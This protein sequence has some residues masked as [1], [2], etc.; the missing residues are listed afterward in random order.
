[1]LNRESIA[2]RIPHQ[3]NMCLLDQVQYW[4]EHVIRCVATSHTDI[5]NPL[6]SHGRLGIAAGIE[7]AAQAMAVH[8]ALLAGSAGS[9]GAPQPGYLGSVRGM[10][11]N[12]VRLDDLPE[13]LQVRAQRL[14]G[15]DKL[16]LY[17]FEVIHREHCVLQGR[18]SVVIDISGISGS[19]S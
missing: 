17:S 13:P 14:S 1:M 4:D 9:T 16:I 6:R 7:Y 8:G 3:G 19:H 11:A 10:R 5:S 12:V 2:A 15:D 18:A